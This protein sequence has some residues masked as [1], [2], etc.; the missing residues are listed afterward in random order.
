MMKNHVIHCLLATLLLISLLTCAFAE[1]PLSAVNETEINE[2]TGLDEVQGLM[3]LGQV[4]ETDGM[5]LEQITET[6][7][8]P[9]M[10]EY[11]NSVTGLSFQ[12]PSHL[13]FSGEENLVAA[14]SDD[15]LE[16]MLVESFEADGLLTVETLTEAVRMED[17]KAVITIHEENG[18]ICVRRVTEDSMIQFDLYL[19]TDKWIHHISLTVPSEKESAYDATVDYMIHSLS[20]EESD[21][22]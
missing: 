4:T 18:C 16:R 2:E 8:D 13:I 22:G 6:F 19:I 12:Y 20:T 7:I 5:D 14:T 9:M 1:E 10:S 3:E 17:A 21:I 15:G 11:Y